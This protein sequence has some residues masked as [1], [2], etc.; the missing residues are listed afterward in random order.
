M[1]NN[2]LAKTLTE[3]Q[4]AFLRSDYQFESGSSAALFPRLN[5][6]SKDQTEGKGKAMKVV[7]EAGTFYIDVQ[8]T[9]VDEET[10]K[11]EWERSEIG[12]EV[13]LIVLFKRKQ[14]VMFDESTE[15]YTS[16]P[17]YD[18][19]DQIIPL[20]SDKKQVGRG[21]PAELKAEYEFEDDDGKT[22][23]KL[24]DERIL[25]VLM[26]GEVYQLNLRGSSMYAFKSYE[27]DLNKSGLV[28]RSVL[29]K[30]TSEEQTKG[31]NTW[32][33]M[34]F[35]NER[36]IQGDEIEVVMEKV[37]EMRD[38]VAQQLA[39]YGGKSEADKTYAA[40]GK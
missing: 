26:N 33:Q 30:I 9:E 35:T 37:G 19:D 38:S 13:E 18:E 8:G 14:L 1:A 27:R 5:M 4:L 22:K 15:K 21:T 10:K 40:L 20:F 2:K 28:P 3:E 36:P 32:N 24:K 23:S 31:S 17:I 29:T 11:K 39:A 34:V 16:S 6:Y 12:S 25:Y 7:S